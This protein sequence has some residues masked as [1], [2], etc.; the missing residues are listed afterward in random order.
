[1]STTVPSPETL[2]HEQIDELTQILED[3][4]R[5]IE[6]Q[7]DASREDAKPVDLDE[8][9]G[10]LTRMDAMQQQNMT[11]ASRRSLEARLKQIA[12]A[13][14]TVEAGDYGL[15]AR[16][17]DPIGYPRLRARPESRLCVRCQEH[18]EAVS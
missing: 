11:K 18:I 15:C 7:L 17:D 4:G 14:A 10:R 1:L 3:L 16:C 9:I 8:P 6:S 13:L 12:G 5:E 2:T